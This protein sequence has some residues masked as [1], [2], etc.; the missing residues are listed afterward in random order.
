MDKDIR[1]KLL[2][3]ADA[4]T[5]ATSDEMQGALT[6]WKSRLSMALTL[7]DEELAA[8]LVEE[9]PITPRWNDNNCQ[10]SAK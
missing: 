5:S 8:K 4:M 2:A 3:D 1:E 10:C 7:E 9:G 6:F